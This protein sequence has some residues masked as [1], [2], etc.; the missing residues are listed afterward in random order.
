MAAPVTDMCTSTFSRRTVRV[1]L[2]KV[3]GVCGPNVL[4]CVCTTISAFQ[5][6][7]AYKAM[8]GYNLLQ[9]CDDGCCGGGALCHSH[10]GII[11]Q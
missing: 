1:G 9:H 6:H 7:C 11:L 2:C 3:I 10:I 8:C 5:Q 4:V